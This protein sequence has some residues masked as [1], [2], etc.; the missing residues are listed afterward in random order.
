M[1]LVG[2][3]PQP[4]QTG[5]VG[6]VATRLTRRF[7]V[8]IG[9]TPSTT[10]EIDWL[11]ITSIRFLVHSEALLVPLW[12]DGNT[13]ESGRS[14]VALTGNPIA[15]PRP[16]WL[17]PTQLLADAPLTMSALVSA[18]TREEITTLTG[19]RTTGLTQLSHA[20]MAAA[21]LRGR[22]GGQRD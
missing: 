3:T 4:G 12:A 10:F 17:E 19:L 1:A 20:S 5:R 6:G 15:G 2:I 14:K 8:S 22:M 9:E 16:G 7:P 18:L 11:S 13:V 21:A